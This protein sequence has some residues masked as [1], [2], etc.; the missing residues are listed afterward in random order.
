[1]GY[2]IEYG[3]SGTWENRWHANRKKRKTKI[4]IAALLGIITLVLVFS[5]QIKTVQDFFIP[6][7]PEITK[8]AF[9]Q[10]KEDI[11]HGDDFD[12]ALTAFCKEIIEH[13]SIPG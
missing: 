2:S 11:R 1:M 10:L 3:A 7:N 5:G 9:A 6:G 13:A 12:A 8:A 4:V